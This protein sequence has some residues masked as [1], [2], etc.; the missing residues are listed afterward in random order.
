MTKENIMRKIKIEK[1]VLSVGG[2]A[3]G[4]DKGFR[5]LKFL[6]DKTTK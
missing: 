3:D 4:L 6:T 1:V 5:L 2:T